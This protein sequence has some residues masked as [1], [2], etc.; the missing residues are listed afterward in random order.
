MQDCIEWKMLAGTLDCMRPN[1]GKRI[2]GIYPSHCKIGQH[3]TMNFRMPQRLSGL[4]AIRGLMKARN[5][6]GQSME[7]PLG[8][9]FSVAADVRQNA[10]GQPI[11][12]QQ[13]GPVAC[14]CREIDRGARLRR[15]AT[16]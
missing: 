16:I 4:N 14:L 7:H 5:I 10:L 12:G 2:G 11:S 9:F 13:L 8:D 6:R 1:V 15:L 3:P